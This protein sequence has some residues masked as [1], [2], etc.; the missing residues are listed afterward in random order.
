[1]T[2]LSIA[3]VLIALALALLVPLLMAGAYLKFRGRRIVTCPETG[4]PAAVEVDARFAAA[5]AV[6]GE[7]SLRLKSCSRW[8]EHKDCDQACLKQIQAAPEELLAQWYA[9][10]TCALCGRPIGAISRRGHYPALM[11]T[12]G[13]TLAWEAFPPEKVPEAL[14]THRPVCGSCHRRRVAPPSLPGAGM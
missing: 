3:A 12:S 2:V 14:A 8:P 5:T 6:L 9:G 10:K 13:R 11:D 1:M 7:P 4:Q